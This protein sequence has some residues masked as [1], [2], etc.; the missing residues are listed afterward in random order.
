MN[1]YGGEG[2][3]ELIGASTLRG[4]PG[5]DTLRATFENPP[6]DG[7]PIGELRTTTSS[8]RCSIATWTPSRLSAQA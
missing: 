6:L 3:D 4:G 1:V 2:D 7:G 8:P 5:D